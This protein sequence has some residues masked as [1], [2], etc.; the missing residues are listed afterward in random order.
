M[1]MVTLKSGQVDFEEQNNNKNKTKKTSGPGSKPAKLAFCSF[2]SSAYSPF[3]RARL[4]PAGR[5][6]AMSFNP[7]A[8]NGGYVP[9]PPRPRAL[10]R[11]QPSR[12]ARGCNGHCR[13]FGPREAQRKLE[14]SL[15]LF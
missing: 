15:A 9:P 3:A 12:A 11:S 8:S 4:Q 6:A 2:F 13:L 1:M 14:V 10:A 5:V 7:Y